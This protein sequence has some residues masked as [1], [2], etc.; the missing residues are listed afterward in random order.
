MT[1]GLIAKD[2]GKSSSYF[3]SLVSV[4]VNNRP[5]PS[6]RNWTPNCPGKKYDPTHDFAYR[7]RRAA[8]AGFDLFYDRAGRRRRTLPLG[9]F[10]VRLAKRLGSSLPVSL[11]PAGSPCVLGCVRYWY[12]R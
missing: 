2:I 10:S 7:A 3:E 12:G 4:R 1:R 6:I 9:V 8:G 11:Q 5:I